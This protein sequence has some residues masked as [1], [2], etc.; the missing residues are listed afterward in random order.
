M[1][2]FSK[3]LSQPY[4]CFVFNIES[5]VCCFRVFKDAAAYAFSAVLRVVPVWASMPLSVATGAPRRNVTFLQVFRSGIC[6]AGAPGHGFVVAT[7]LQILRA[8]RAVVG[9]RLLG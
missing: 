2:M 9:F 8:R 6:G 7:V 3:L 4:V 5:D 1:V